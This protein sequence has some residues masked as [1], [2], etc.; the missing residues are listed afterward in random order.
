MRRILQRSDD[1][2]KSLSSFNDFSV[3]ITN[4]Q[5]ICFLVLLFNKNKQMIQ[6]KADMGK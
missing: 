4:A 6:N 3:A 5:G 1:W 2:R